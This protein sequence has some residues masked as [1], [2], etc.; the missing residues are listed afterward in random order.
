MK[1][2]SNLIGY[3]YSDCPMWVHTLPKNKWKGPLFDPEKLKIESG[4]K[5]L[6]DLATQYYKVTNKAIRRYDKNHL[7]LGDRYE[8]H[9][10]PVPVEVLKAAN[11]FVD[12]F[13]FQHFG[14]VKLIQKDLQ[15]FHEVT[16]KPVLLADSSRGGRT[17]DDGM[18]QHD[19]AADAQIL[20]KIRDI[21]A[22]IGFHLCGGYLR[23]YA[24]NRALKDE[25]DNSDVETI[26]IITKANRD[27]EEW[28]L[29]F[30]KK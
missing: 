5:E 18:E 23:N 17:R 14:E 26:K 13:S 1:D 22:C 24:R 25:M 8:A 29:N 6:F 16:G 10:A 30:D 20:E 15:R 11:P 27:T 7:I 2:D 9:A 12:V 28:V 19:G 21:S 4:R 3:F